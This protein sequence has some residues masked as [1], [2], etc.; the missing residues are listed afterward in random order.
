MA[1]GH[2]RFLDPFSPDGFDPRLAEST[3]RYY[4]AKVRTPSRKQSM[5]SR[6]CALF[7][8]D[9]FDVAIGIKGWDTIPVQK[10]HESEEALSENI[11]INRHTMEES[12]NLLYA[13]FPKAAAGLR[14][15]GEQ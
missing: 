6:L 8:G 3:V 11:A 10:H 5:L 2:M 7:T 13:Y 4:I 15:N 9:R 12:N 14:K 1:D